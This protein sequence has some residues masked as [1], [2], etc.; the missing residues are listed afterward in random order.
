MLKQ[1]LNSSENP[2]ICEISYPFKQNFTDTRSCLSVHIMD[3][4]TTLEYAILPLCTS[5]YTEEIYTV[6]HVELIVEKDAS[7]ETAHC[8][9]KQENYLLSYSHLQVT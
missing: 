9:T 2:K 1:N 5:N 6:Q 7:T 3:T 8:I 4:E